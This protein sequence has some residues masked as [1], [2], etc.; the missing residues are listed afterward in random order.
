MNEWDGFFIAIL[1]VP[2]VSQHRAVSLEGFQ[3]IV[4]AYR[5]MRSMQG[6]MHSHADV[7]TIVT[8]PRLTLRHA[9][10]LFKRC[11]LHTAVQNS[12]FQVSASSHRPRGVK[13]I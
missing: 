8:R 1:W 12:G 4:H 9:R 13:L 6:D 10:V 2:L 3:L 11:N 5:D 7:S